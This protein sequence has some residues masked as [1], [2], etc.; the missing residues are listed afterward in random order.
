MAGPIETL[1]YVAR[2]LIQFEQRF[3]QADPA[4]KREAASLFTQIAGSVQLLAHDLG[5]DHLPHEACRELALSSTRLRVCAG[6]PLGQGEAE[7]LSKSLG[8]ACDKEKLYL[9]YRSA[10]DQKALAEELEKAAI[11][12]QA[13]ANGLFVAPPAPEV[14]TPFA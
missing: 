6:D 11:L 14:E 1:S 13:L 2:R 7:R 4:R 9:Q 8:E 12:I 10:P 5:R 3:A